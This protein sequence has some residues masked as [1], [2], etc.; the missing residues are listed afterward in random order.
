LKQHLRLKD[1]SK[2]TGKRL[3]KNWAQAAPELPWYEEMLKG[4]Y[5][6]LKATHR[7]TATWERAQ[8]LAIEQY[9]R[10]CVKQMLADSCI[11]G[12]RWADEACRFAARMA[13]TLQ[14]EDLLEL[15]EVVPQEHWEKLRKEFHELT[16]EIADLVEEIET[17]KGAKPPR[18]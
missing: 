17:K 6:T 11:G 4:T 1:T 3:P 18:G 9:G 7:P 15:K 16:G 14:P 5:D 12:A 10:K 8:Q 13:A 2:W